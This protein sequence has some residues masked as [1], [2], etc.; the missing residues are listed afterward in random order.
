MHVGPYLGQNAIILWPR[1][2]VFLFYSVW[3]V[4]GCIL[5][6]LPSSKSL[7]IVAPYC[8]IIIKQFAFDNLILIKGTGNVV[9]DVLSRIDTESYEEMSFL[10]SFLC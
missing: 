6:V 4:L 9:P 3:N 2:N 7:Q 10:K 1:E 5:T 8:G